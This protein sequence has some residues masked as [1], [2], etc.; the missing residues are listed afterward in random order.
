[1]LAFSREKRYAAASPAS[2][3]EW[4]SPM[5]KRIARTA[6]AI[7][8]ACAVSTNSIASQSKPYNGAVLT[9]PVGSDTAIRFFY[10]SGGD[11]IVGPLIFRPVEENDPLLNTAP[12][13]AE[14]TVAYVSRGEMSQLLQDLAQS[15]LSW[16]E[17]RKSRPLEPFKIPDEIMLAMEVE[18]VSSQGT[19]KANLKPEAICGKLGPLQPALKTARAGLEFQYFR[20]F[21]ECVVAGF[22][23]L[24]Y[25]Q[26]IQKER[27]TRLPH[28]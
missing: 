19:A 22:D 10:Y 1:M 27:S 15:N 18:V 4:V 2:D 25:W 3:T 11:F 6:L 26:L 12:V 28:P 17:T 7:V 16:K 21:H 24:A 8:F 9:S 23:Q 14:G 13:L 5:R 20:S